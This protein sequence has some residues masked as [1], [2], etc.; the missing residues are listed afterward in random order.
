MR[1]ILPLIILFVLL[2]PSTAFAKDWPAQT[3]VP[4]D[5]VWTVK[6]NKPIRLIDNFYELQL[7]IK[8]TNGNYFWD[9]T[10][11]YSNDMK[12]LTITPTKNYEPETT[13][14]LYLTDKIKSYSKKNLSEPIIMRFTTAE[15][16]PISQVKFNEDQLLLTEGGE[17]FTL[18]LVYY[19]QNATDKDKIKWC[20]TSSNP[21]V[22]TVKDGIVI[23]LKAGK[24]I[25]E[26]YNTQNACWPS[27]YVSVREKGGQ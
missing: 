12:T 6:F 10:L 8:N 27:C 13:Y 7:Y 20:W 23:P 15:Y 17:P 4:V 14:F 5:K 9:W 11:N 19:P 3:N 16:I 26:A 24:T 25:I 21:E 22:A 18:K 2:L 1:K